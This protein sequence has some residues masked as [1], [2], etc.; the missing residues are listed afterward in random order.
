MK[1]VLII[2]EV[3]DYTTWK[4]GFDKAANIR[5]EAGEIAYQVLVDDD[6]QN[7]VVHFSSWKNHE[8]AKAF[9]ESDRVKAIRKNLGV[10]QPDFI[11]L[12]ELENGIL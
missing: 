8:Q 5:K 4:I 6:E 7:K 9:F 2:H 11:Y 10:K 12:N 3:E 1:F